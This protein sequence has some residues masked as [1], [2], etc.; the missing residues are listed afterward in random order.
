M[1]G[2]KGMKHYA[3]ELKLEA[4]RMFFEEGM[5][6]AEITQAL[7]IRSEGRVET[8]VRQYRREGPAGFFKPIG[9][10]RKQAESEEVEVERLRMENALLKKYHTDLRKRLLAKRNIGQSTI[11]EEDTK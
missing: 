7:G 11:T 4:V 9:R 3:G 8:W 10:P 5:T 2:K 6:Q 1:A